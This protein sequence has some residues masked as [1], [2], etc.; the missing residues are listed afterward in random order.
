MINTLR[1]SV[2]PSILFL[3]GTN[4]V[5]AVSPKPYTLVDENA[6]LGLPLTNSMVT[7]WVI[8]LLIILVIR[9]LAGKPQLIPTKG[10]AFV[11]NILGGIRDIIEPVVGKHM[12]GPTFPLLIG[13][14]TFILI[15]NW[16]GLLPGVGAFGHFDEH[17]HFSYWFRPGNADLN[18][19]FALGI[20]AAVGG[21]GYFVLRYAGPKTLFLD[22]FGNKADPKETPTPI[23]ILLFPIFFLVGLIEVVSILF[24]P[25][26]LS[27]RLFGNVFGGE[28]LMTN[29]T[30]LFSWLLPIP[31]Y[32]LE[33]LIGLVQALVFMLLTAVY[34]GLIC[35]HGEE[36]HG[37]GP[38]SA[39]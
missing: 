25:V 10:Q 13:L 2:L 26:S 17:G 14:F 12:I 32:F 35:N 6:F 8:S 22:I 18:M 7:S 27:F 38:A 5:S 21:W 1:N 16:S 34:I 15:H 28:N 11:E 30:D 3:A 29:M 39:H 31:F 4:C 9:S 23:Y 37:H 33:L 24:R 20:V 19:T 36:D